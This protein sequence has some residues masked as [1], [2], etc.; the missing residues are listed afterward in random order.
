V[1]VCLAY[2]VA[3]CNSADESK[4]VEDSKIPPIKDKIYSRNDSVRTLSD[5]ER[6]ANVT[7][8]DPRWSIRAMRAIKRLHT[9]FQHK[10]GE[11]WKTHL[12]L[13]DIGSNHVN[14]FYHGLRH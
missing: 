5:V 13:L 7:S 2:L 3:Q 10:D 12:V 1:M 6:W 14:S 9:Y 8:F 4:I 11:L